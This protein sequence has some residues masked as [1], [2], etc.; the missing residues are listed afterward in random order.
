MLEGRVRELQRTLSQIDH[1]RT[2]LFRLINQSRQLT[3][4]SII[5]EEDYAATQL[6]KSQSELGS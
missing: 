5:S 1:S 4:R 3:E 2:S 6:R